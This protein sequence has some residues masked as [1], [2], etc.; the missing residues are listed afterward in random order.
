MESAARQAEQN[1]QMAEQQQQV[2]EGVRQL[3]EADA[4]AR[5]ELAEMQRESWCPL[6]LWRRRRQRWF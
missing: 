1:Q 5:Q 3:V 6:R 4:R 2:A